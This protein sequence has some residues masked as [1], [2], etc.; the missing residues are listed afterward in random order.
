MTTI[1]ITGANRGLGL[2]F[3]RQY[4]DAGANVIAACRKPSAA[5]EALAGQSPGLRIEQL[6]VADPQSITALGPRLAG[7]PVDILVNNAGIYGPRGQSIDQIDAGAWAEVF[8]VNAIAPLQ[9][10]RALLPNLKASG[11]PR[12]MTITSRMGSI[13][14]TSGGNYIYRSSKSAVNMVMRSLALDMKPTGIAI[15]LIHPGWVR[16]DMGGPGATLSP[17]ESVT[18]IRRVID[19]LSMAQTGT[20]FNFDG[21]TIPW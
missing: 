3:C 6:D 20:Y 12:V 5:L 8:A 9:I 2:E 21:S 7:I 17:A 10:I 1:L 15:A 18:G 19:Q 16:T 4:A 11:Q 14:E 13:G